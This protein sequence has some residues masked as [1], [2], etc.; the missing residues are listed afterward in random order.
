MLKNK[1]FG[2]KDPTDKIPL[3]AQEYNEK[4][5]KELE[6]HN[7]DVII[8]ES[9]ANIDRLFDNLSLDQ[10]VKTTSKTCEINFSM[11]DDDSQKWHK[12][13]VDESDTMKNIR[14]LALS[15]LSSHVSENI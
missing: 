9:K 11:V 5:L 1:A 7:G 3:T 10:Q 12:I 13:S 4:S 2:Q 14:L 15:F 6:V 8:A